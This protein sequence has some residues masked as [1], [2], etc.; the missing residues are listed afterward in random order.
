[1]LSTLTRTLRRLARDES[2]NALPEYAIV[3]T[4]VTVI[5]YLA[6]LSLANTSSNAVVT[7]Q[8]NLSASG[9][10]SYATP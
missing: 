4:A 1:L 6:F 7:N 9:A 2:A 5:T 10:A 3:M 8:N